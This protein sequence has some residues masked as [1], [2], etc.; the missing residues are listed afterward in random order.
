MFRRPPKRGLLHQVCCT[1]SNWLLMLVHAP[2][3]HALL[4]PAAAI[5]GNLRISSGQ[6]MSVATL[7][8]NRLRDKQVTLRRVTLGVRA[9]SQ[10]GVWRQA[11]PSE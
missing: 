8:L 7:L 3:M 4:T 6:L 9:Q 5:Q 2:E 1:N 10:Y 11:F